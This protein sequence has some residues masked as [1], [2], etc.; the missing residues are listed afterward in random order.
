MIS[1]IGLHRKAWKLNSELV[2][3]RGCNKRGFGNC[4]TC[5]KKIHWKKSNA[6]H[7]IHLKRMDF[8]ENN[9]QRQCIRCNLRLHGNLGRFAYCLIKRYDM[10]EIERLEALRYVDRKIKRQELEEIIIKLKE[11]LLKMKK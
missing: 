2:R 5:G 7:Y 8:D 4:F 9:I 3:R 6:G 11:Q 1:L 10:I